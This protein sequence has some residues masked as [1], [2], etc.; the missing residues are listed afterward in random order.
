MDWMNI[1]SMDRPNILATP[2]LRRGPMCYRGE[3]TGQSRGTMLENT[4]FALLPPT[5]SEARCHTLFLGHNNTPNMNKIKIKI[6]IKTKMITMTITHI[7]MTMLMM[8]IIKIQN[9]L[10]PLSPHNHP[11]LLSPTNRHLHQTIL[12]TTNQTPHTIH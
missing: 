8:M 2:S 7:F 1:I 6:K 4:D 3:C 10:Y 9:K 12:Q 5:L 11:H